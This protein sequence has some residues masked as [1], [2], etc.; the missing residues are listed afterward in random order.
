LGGERLQFV[1]ADDAADAGSVGLLD[2]EVGGC[3]CGGFGG[4]CGLT[5]RL[6]RGRRRL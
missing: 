1:G 6:G 2:W 4:R 3:E 5:G